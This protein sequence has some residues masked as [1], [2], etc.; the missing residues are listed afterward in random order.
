MASAKNWFCLAYRNNL[1]NKLMQTCIDTTAIDPV[2]GKAPNAVPVAF[3][4]ETIS[5]IMGISCTKTTS[6]D[7]AFLCDVSGYDSKI[8]EVRM[9]ITAAGVISKENETIYE[10]YGDAYGFTCSSHDMFFAGP[11]DPSR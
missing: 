4:G 5:D 6:A 7:D 10:K 1:D 8:Y 11:I 9:K 3:A 2:T